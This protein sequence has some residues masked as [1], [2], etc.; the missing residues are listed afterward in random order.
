MA[1]VPLAGGGWGC[2]CV[3]V[4][5]GVGWGGLGGVNG[6]EVLMLITASAV[7]GLLASMDAFAGVN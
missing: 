4:W 3:C 6:S 5:G 2:V 1:D 7:S